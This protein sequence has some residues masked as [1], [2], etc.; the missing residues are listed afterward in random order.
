MCRDLEIPR[1]L[2]ILSIDKNNFKTLDG[3]RLYKMS[4]DI[5][6]IDENVVSKKIFI[7]DY[8]NIWADHKRTDLKYITTEQDLSKENIYFPNN[9]KIKNKGL[10]FTLTKI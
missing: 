10:L 9:I 5:K 3:R 2:N 8:S 1:F 7:K 6:K 4:L